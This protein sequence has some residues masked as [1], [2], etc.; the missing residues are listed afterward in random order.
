MCTESPES[1]AAAATRVYWQTQEN[2]STA[3]V[4]YDKIARYNGF[5]V[6]THELS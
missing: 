2:N 1:R 5:I 3:R 4:L 6:Y